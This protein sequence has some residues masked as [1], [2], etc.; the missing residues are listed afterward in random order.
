VVV[1]GGVVGL[2]KGGECCCCFCHQHAH[3]DYCNA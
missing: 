1:V 3:H 2:L